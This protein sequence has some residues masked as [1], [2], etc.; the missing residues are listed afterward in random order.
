MEQHP[1][2]QHIASF[3]FKLFGNLTVRQF[4][5]LAIPMSL[6][7]LVFFSALPSLIRYP[8]AIIIGLF[9]FFAA[10]VPINGRP[11]D[12]WFVSFIKAVLSPTQRIW[13]KET[14]IPEFLSIVTA[15]QP[16]EETV[17]ESITA[18]GRE[19]L[20]AYLRSLP[21]GTVTPLDVKEQIAVERIGLEGAILPSGAQA[22]EGKL[23]PPI[24]WP[25]GSITGGRQPLYAQGSLPQINAAPWL[26]TAQT[27]PKVQRI[28]PLFEQYEGEMEEALPPIST[29][30]TTATPRINQ[31]AKVFAVPGL[32]KSS[33]RLREHNI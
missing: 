10:L 1:V 8:L 15:P 14:K 31:H 30:K 13:V 17:P 28:N 9:A 21:K 26:S 33:K 3:E 32:E 18:Q 5:T 12:K 4:I 7:A 20:K 24:I 6:A 23:P 11:L 16:Q 25:T 19:R 2:P 22:Q 27:A 29:T